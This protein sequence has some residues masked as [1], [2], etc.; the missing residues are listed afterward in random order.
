MLIMYKAVDVLTAEFRTSVDAYLA[1]QAELNELPVR[2]MSDIAEREDMF[3]CGLDM[4]VSAAESDGAGPGATEHHKMRAELEPRVDAHH[5]Q[6]WADGGETSLD[7]LVTL[8]R[9]HPMGRQP[10]GHGLGVGIR[11]CRRSLQQSSVLQEPQVG[12][13]QQ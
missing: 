1:T 12:D 4:L 6:H 3:K 13:N 10:H 8:C 11:I 9:H 5:I 7:N 2:S